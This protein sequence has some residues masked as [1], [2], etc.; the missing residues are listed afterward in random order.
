MKKNIVIAV[1]ILATMLSFVGCDNS[2]T[3]A[4][5]K[6][7]IK[8]TSPI[9]SPVV[10][11]TIM[12]E[13]QAIQEIE[14]HDAIAYAFNYAYNLHYDWAYIESPAVVAQNT[15]HFLVD[16]TLAPIEGPGGGGHG[17]YRVNKKTGEVSTLG[18]GPVVWQD[19]D[20]NNE[21]GGKFI[22]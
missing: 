6:T 19:F 10:E 16:I 20:T 11:E 8:E 22:Q 5:S 18:E 1:L 4:V 9:E 12:P 15:T 13:K 2:S 21:F 7:D 14:P 17:Y 3:P